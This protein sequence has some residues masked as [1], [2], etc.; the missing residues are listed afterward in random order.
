MAA[1]LY[2]NHMNNSKKKKGKEKK[3]R[4][5]TVGFFFKQTNGEEKEGSSRSAFTNL[6]IPDW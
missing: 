1:V 4:F 5:S 3:W 2:H 6:C